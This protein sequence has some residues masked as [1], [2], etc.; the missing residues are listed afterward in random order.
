[1]GKRGESSVG[2][3]VSLHLVKR[4]PDAE[5]IRAALPSSLDFR[6]YRHAV[7][8]VFAIDTFGASN[9]PRHPFTSQTPAAELSLEFGPHLR[10]LADAFE[11]ARRSGGANGIKRSYI[12][13]AEALSGA[14]G[15]PV[16]S[17]CSD[18]DDSDFTCL[19]E[20]GLA[21]VVTA[22]C[23]ET[24]VRHANGTTTVT[25]AGDALTLHRHAVE[26]F[27]DF[28]GAGAGAVGLGSWDPPADLGFVLAGE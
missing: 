10:A 4:R 20:G 9:P 11:D 22:L 1:L 26:A 16:L 28:T 21:S 18:D 3:L 15:Q 17:I 12:N 8:D 6:V 25:P 27:E 7:L 14:L 24:V 13:L 23:D 2:Y 19:A 5:A